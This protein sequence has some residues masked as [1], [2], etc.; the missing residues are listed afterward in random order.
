MDK[1]D[2]EGKEIKD[3]NKGLAIYCM[4]NKDRDV[5]DNIQTYLKIPHILIADDYDYVT[6]TWINLRS[7]NELK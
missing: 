5:I 1:I 7:I 4:E 3:L 6:N 2:I